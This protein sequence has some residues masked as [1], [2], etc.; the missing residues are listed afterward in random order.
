M[1]PKDWDA[2]HRPPPT[3]P[4]PELP[5]LAGITDADQ[6]LFLRFYLRS[7]QDV[8]QETARARCAAWGIDYEEARNEAHRS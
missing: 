1:P 2:L 6:R 3:V 4:R 8:D 5:A 7:N